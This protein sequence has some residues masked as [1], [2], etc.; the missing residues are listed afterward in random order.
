[1]RRDG[2][3]S[4]IR[5]VRD[6]RLALAALLA[7]S[8]T[9][10]VALTLGFA[11][12][13]T[14][15]VLVPA[16]A[17]PAWEVGSGGTGARYL[18]DMARTVAVT[19]LT[20]TPENAGHVRQAVARLSHASARGAVG[21][22]VEAEAA[23]MAG[24]DMASAFYPTE[25]E[26]DPEG[27]H[28]RGRGRARDL[29]RS[30]GGLARGPALP[31]RL[32]D[33]RR[34]DRAPALRTDGEWKMTLR[35][36]RL[37]MALLSLHMLAAGL[38]AGALPATAMQVLDAVDNAELAAEISATG[39][40]RITLGHDRI[41]RVVRSPDGFAV[42]HDAATGDLYLR[43]AVPQ[44]GTVATG[45]SG[46]GVEG[47]PGP[48]PVTLFIGTE[49]GFTYR[50][51]LTPTGRD[52][53]QV[54]IRNADAIPA[55]VTTGSTSGGDPHVAALVRLVRAVARREPLPGHEILA[56]GGNPFNGIRIVE[57]WRGSRLSA[58]VLEAD[59]LP[60]PS[61]ASAAAGLA[62]TLQEALA[63]GR[64]AALWLA[65]PETGPN[66]GRLAVAV[67]ETAGQGA[68]R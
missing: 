52:S 39:V 67:V 54:L 65:G 48:Y 23:R 64:L 19:L 45:P 9:G 60:A 26:A 68:P 55:A 56:G 50:L 14:V 18:E 49:R 31:A 61:G 22:W 42:E 35:Y 46:P 3:E 38:L 59:A 16:V 24:R 43:P 28:G 2:M 25:I 47:M 5:R 36:L 8:M 6:I 1:M 27:A 44:P 13:E 10:N 51:A 20:L 41:A 40:S 62:G 30:R 11:G 37:R 17:G 34:A 63:K 53:A 66:G 7:L 32:P 33:R 57:T 58:L 15:T 4:A 29:D 12:R 21:A